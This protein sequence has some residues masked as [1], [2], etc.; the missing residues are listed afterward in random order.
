[1][2]C[3]ACFIS[4]EEI[5]NNLNESGVDC[6]YIYSGSERQ[7]EIAKRWNSDLLKVLVSTTIGLV[8]NESTKTQ[9]VCIVGLLYNIPSIIQSIGRIRPQRRNDDSQCSIFTRVNNEFL[10]ENVAAKNEADFAQLVGCQLLKDS[11]RG[12][13]LKSMTMSSVHNW[14]FN[15]INDGGC[16]VVSLCSRLGYVH[17]KCNKCDRCTNTS[18]NRSKVVRRKRKD[19]NKGRK[20]AGIKLLQ[21]LKTKCIVCNKPH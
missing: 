19:L 7:S 14:L 21:T 1:M 17:L 9:T 13:Y 4:G 15:D 6:E 18:V 3:H 16:R 11:H 20:D 2:T 12:K 8:G 5:Y 10:L